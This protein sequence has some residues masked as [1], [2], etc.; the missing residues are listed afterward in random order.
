[1]AG[2]AIHNNPVIYKITSPSGK[3]YIGQT[4]NWS[5]RENFY[6]TLNC[7]TQ[8]GIYNSLLKY[9]YSS[10][11]V[12]IVCELPKD[13]SQEALDRYELI[14]WEFYKDCNI[15]LLNCREPGR[16]G[17]FSEESKLKL[18]EALKGRK[19]SEEHRKKVTEKN[20][21]SEEREKRRNTLKGH[22]ISEE[23]RK[24]ISDRIKEKW[25]NKEYSK[26]KKKEFYKGKPII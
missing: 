11:N 7:K 5:V 1:M 17:K 3:I 4:W 25:A 20:K 8:T 21:S 19:L 15:K 10:H 13:I 6:R 16:G 22:I 2:D 12:K 14:Y 26:R 23:T 18:S 24:K 9:G